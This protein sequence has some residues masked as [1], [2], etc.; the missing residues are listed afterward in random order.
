ML[1]SWYI[2]RS[3]GHTKCDSKK[4]AKE[5]FSAEDGDMYCVYT[6]YHSCPSCS[7]SKKYYF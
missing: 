1:K 4:Q 3:N 6:S 2:I 7:T 5:L